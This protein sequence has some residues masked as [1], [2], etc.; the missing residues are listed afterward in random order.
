MNRTNTVDCVQNV[1]ITV[2]SIKMNASLIH[3]PFNESPV[4]I[5]HNLFIVNTVA[6]MW[7]AT[8]AISYFIKWTRTDSDTGFIA[9]CDTIVMTATDRKMYRSSVMD[10]E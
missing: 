8:A 3:S 1:P 5:V 7:N 2:M 6:S 10:V 9:Y 4:A